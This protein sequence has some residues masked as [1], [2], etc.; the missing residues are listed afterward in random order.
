M[1]KHVKFLTTVGDTSEIQIR[2]II[3]STLTFAW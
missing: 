2:V 3:V 1:R